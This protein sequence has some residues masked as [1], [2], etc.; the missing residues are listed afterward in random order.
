[1]TSN[2]VSILDVIAD[3]FPRFMGESF[4]GWRAILAAAFGLPVEDMELIEKLTKRTRLPLRQ[5]AELYLVCGRRAGKSLVCALLA[6]Y[7]TCYRSYPNLIPGETAQF[8]VVSASKQ[9]AKA[10]KRYF[11]GLLRTRPELAAMIVGETDESVSLS[12]GID[13]VVL[14]G[15][16][17]TVRS[18]TIIS[19]LIDEAAFL[20]NEE[21]GSS[22]TDE[23]LVG[24]LLPGMATIDDAMLMVLSSPY[25]EQGILFDAYRE[26]FGNDASDDVLVVQADTRSLNPTIKQSV[27]DRLYAKDPAKAASEYGA[28]FRTD[29]ADFIP[30]AVVEA[31]VSPGVELRAPVPGRVYAAH[32]DPA[33]GTGQ[34]SFTLAIASN[35]N[36]K[37]VLDLLLEYRPPF[38]PS[39]VI[40]QIVAACRAYRVERVVGDS[41]AG[42][43]S[44]EQFQKNGMVYEKCSRNRSQ[45][46]LDVLPLLNSASVDL[47]DDK[48]MVAQFANL[49]RRT[50]KGGKDSVD[51]K[52]GS[53]DDLVTSVAGALVA[54]GASDAPQFRVRNF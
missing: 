29:L 35:V 31:C 42:G 34:D 7:F 28:A 25:R 39:E 54:V 22:N 37:A 44:G 24:A 2:E 8:V 47:L 48:R 51:H 52:P 13:L 11:L 30:R 41:Y 38:K 14:A 3:K 16:Y 4:A 21:D 49:E 40:A 27:I 45:L 46:Y 6:V 5:V 1:V 18:G 43:F 53:H 19:S 23:E 10:V 15:N 12:N 32:V 50:A 33:G 36:G 17:R 26:H 20:R 9:Q